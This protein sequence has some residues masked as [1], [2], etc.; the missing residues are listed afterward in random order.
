MMPKFFYCEH[1]GNIVEMIH[2]SGAPLTCCGDTM[3]SLVAGSVDAALEKHVPVYD[4]V[5]STVKVTVGSTAHPMLPEHFIEWI[6]LKTNQGIQRKPLS[7]GDAP[8]SSFILAQG[9][10]IEGILAY[11]NLH[12]LWSAEIK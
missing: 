5:D 2:D 8:E 1:C 9:E 3:K 11:C 10:K 4:I 7:P 6:L 12:G